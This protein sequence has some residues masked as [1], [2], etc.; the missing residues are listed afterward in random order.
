MKSK[1]ITKLYYDDV[2]LTSNIVQM[3]MTETL[4]DILNI[5]V[6]VIQKT[7]SLHKVDFDIRDI[8]TVEFKSDDNTSLYKQYIIYRKENVDIEE[9]KNDIYN[10]TVALFVMDATVFSLTYNSISYHIDENHNVGLIQSILSK[11]N[12]KSSIGDNITNLTKKE[13][14]VPIK[15]HIEIINKLNNENDSFLLLNRIN[16]K[17]I[18]FLSWYNILNDDIVD[19]FDI[20]KNKYDFTNT[21][22]YNFYSNFNN[23]V[24]GYK[25]GLYINENGKYEY[26]SFQSYS[27][28]E[29]ENLPF[30][31]SRINRLNFLN[32]NTVKII[33]PSNKKYQL[34][35][36]IKIINNTISNY[37]GEFII[38]K[39]NHIV[40]K[41]G[42][43]TMELILSNLTLMFN[44]KRE[45]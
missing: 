10:E 34:G 7:K 21:S 29:M 30:Y 40:N 42:N 36:K 13:Y 1:P 32:D 18:D 9:Q 15:P 11:N 6:I 24:Y 23:G 5:G 22:K 33:I 2:E 19:S 17:K 27:E 41:F 26:N 43:W 44:N 38:I 35:K 8:L 14:V 37:D 12:I 25:T 16:S 31:I 20:L 45:D 3:S 28:L 4:N 39:I